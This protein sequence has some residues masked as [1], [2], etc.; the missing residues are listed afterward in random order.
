MNMTLPVTGNI[1]SDCEEVS[2]LDPRQ[3]CP[4]VLTDLGVPPPLFCGL[5]FPKYHPVV[6]QFRLT[7]EDSVVID[8]K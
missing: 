4:T 7:F 6:N 1:K 3:F 5:H 2:P 8:L